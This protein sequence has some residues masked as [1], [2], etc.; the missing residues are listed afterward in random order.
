MMVV[1]YNLRSSE[2]PTFDGNDIVINP[3]TLK[4][5]KC[6]GYFSFPPTHINVYTRCYGFILTEWKGRAC[7][8]FSFI[9]Y[10]IRVI[11]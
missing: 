3:F 4:V 11:L 5:E 6:P 7:R 10:T 2:L 8:T 1:L 9:L